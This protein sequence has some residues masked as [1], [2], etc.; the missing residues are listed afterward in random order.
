MR[1][2]VILFCACVCVL[3]WWQRW[4][5]NSS[6]SDHHCGLIGL[7]P[8]QLHCLRGVFTTNVCVCVCVCVFISIWGVRAECVR[9]KETKAGCFE[10]KR[11]SERR[12]FCKLHVYIQHFT[13]FSYHVLLALQFKIN[14]LQ[15][16]WLNRGSVNSDR[17]RSIYLSIHHPSIHPLSSSILYYTIL[18]YTIL[19]QKFGIITIFKDFIFMKSHML[20]K[21]AF[22]W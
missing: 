5:I 21:T 9:R 16:V 8:V 18:Y 3:G 11:E 17:F 19:S 13:A 14:D 15:N 20:I 4:S 12:L 22:S 1:A 2:C 6:W 10:R 7:N